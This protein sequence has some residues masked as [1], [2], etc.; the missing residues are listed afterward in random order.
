MIARIRPILFTVTSDVTGLLPSCMRSGEER[1]L[2]SATKITSPQRLDDCAVW[3]VAD[4]Y[5]VDGNN[6]V[7]G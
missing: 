5:A 3:T 7:T 2:G 4:P 6:D 1:Q